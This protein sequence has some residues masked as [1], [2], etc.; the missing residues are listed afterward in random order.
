[1]NRLSLATSVFLFC[2]FAPITIQ[3]ATVFGTENGYDAGGTEPICFVTNLT[4]ASASIVDGNPRIDL[5]NSRL[6]G[7]NDEVVLLPKVSPM[8]PI[9]DSILSKCR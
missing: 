3:A 8:R 5:L 2:C 4:D 9:R 7:N 6:Y 1:M